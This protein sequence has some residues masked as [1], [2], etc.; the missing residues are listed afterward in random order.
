MHTHTH[1]MQE[2]ADT[3]TH[4]GQSILRRCN[5]FVPLRYSFIPPLLCLYVFLQS[6]AACE[7]PASSSPAQADTNDS[8]R[9]APPSNGTP[10]EDQ[11]GEGE[12]ED[13]STPPHKV[14]PPLSV[15]VACVDSNSG[16]TYYWDKQTNEVSWTLPEGGNLESSGGVDADDQKPTPAEEEGSPQA[17][18]KVLESPQPLDREDDD[19][20][21][22]GPQPFSSSSLVKDEVDEAVSS[23]CETVAEHTALLPVDKT[24]SSC[25]SEDAD[26]TEPR[27]F[28]EVTVGGALVGYHSSS[29]SDED[30]DIDD[31]LDRALNTDDSALDRCEDGK[32]V[33][34]RADVTE[35]DEATS[36]KKL[37]D[38][39]S[40][41]KGQEDRGEEDPGIGEVRDEQSMEKEEEGVVCDEATEREME[42]T[43]KNV[44]LPISC[45]VLLH[46]HMYSALSTCTYTY[47]LLQYYIEQ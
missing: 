41:Q 13:P 17:S 23:E 29:G 22:Y 2:H 26:S 33:K 14:Q 42:Q 30:S 40:E 3:Y 43:E 4:I 9:A 11:E 1:A 31:M 46:V 32:G 20:V 35:E 6:I 38:S 8:D 19:A 45:V 37:R 34:R 21:G 12:G 27:T 18:T 15:W 36:S 10:D 16:Y 25:V 39:E 7:E 28:S 44:S 47:M 24:P 5:S